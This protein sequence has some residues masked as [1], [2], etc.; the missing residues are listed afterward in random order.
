MSRNKEIQEMKKIEE[1]LRQKF[2]QAK[3]NEIKESK[4]K[5]KG[6][7]ALSD[8][9]RTDQLDSSSLLHNKQPNYSY[10]QMKKT[11]IKKFKNEKADEII[12]D[13]EKVKLYEPITTALEKVEHAVE[14]VNKGIHDSEKHLKTSY[15]DLLAISPTAS[16]SRP[17]DTKLDFPLT[18]SE[19]SSF[20]QSVVTPTHSP[21][22]DPLQKIISPSLERNIV[23][24]PIAK[25]YL[26]RANDTKFGIWYDKEQKQYKIG[27]KSITLNNDD[28]TIDNVVFK[29]T[30]GLWRLLTYTNAPDIDLYTQDDLDKYKSILYQTDSVYQN[31][32]RKSNKPKSSS[33]QKYTTLIK[34]I[35]TQ[36]KQGEHTGQGILKYED[37]PIEYKHVSNLGELLKRL[38][39][40]YA[41]EQ[42]GNNNFHN[43]KL[44][45]IEFIKNSLEKIV[46]SPKGLEY[47]IRI[48]PS[49]PKGCINNGSGLF[50]DLINNL[51][52]ELHAPGYH[53]L[54]P[55]TKLDER[56]KR[57]DKPINKLDEHAQQHDIF[58]KAN[59]D[60]KERHKADYV[61]EN[62][63]WER[64]TAP[65]AD[66]N[67]KS[68]AW[69]TTNTMKAKRY[70]GLGLKF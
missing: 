48:V 67:E 41:Q 44:G 47:L 35:Y 68:W 50:N 33:G 43:E 30:N 27:N 7:P 40:L 46:D 16:R 23:L 15:K 29:G 70:F 56:L 10:K 24:G 18:M 45:V 66:I 22:V 54:G 36:F 19:F 37:N 31:N 20:D 49:L 12:H 5:N 2:K 39:Y 51:P 61:L 62:R 57:G 65:D 25:E 26:P 60:T 53:Y 6:S 14:K 9:V 21:R 13:I 69:V 3:A 64:V 4:I 42:A 59:K 11:L 17:M 1:Q 32:D 34:N 63:A 28:I 38:Q 55:G 52:F 8:V 58:Y